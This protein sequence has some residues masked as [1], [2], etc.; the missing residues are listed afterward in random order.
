MMNIQRHE[1]QQRELQVKEMEIVLPFAAISRASLAVAGGKAANLGELTQAGFPVPSGFC[2]TTEAYALVAE[3]AD[4]EPILAELAA[5]RSDDTMQLA[6]VA[7]AVRARLL[8]APMPERVGEAIRKAYGELEH[9]E[10]VPVAVRSSATAE[11]LPFASFAGQQET[12][13]NIIGIEA[14][15]DAVR[16][17]WASLWTDR[18]V[19]Y[20]VSLGIDQRAVRLAVAVQRMVEADVAGVLFTADPLTGRRRQAV[21]DANPGLGEAVVSGAVNPDHFVV[22]TTTGEIVERRLGDKRLVIRATAGGGTQ[23]VELTG[24]NTE[25][26]L[27]DEQIRTLA[28]LGA[29]VEAHYGAPQDTEWA[30]DPS[31][32]LWLLQSRPITTLYPLPDNAPK[33]DDIL[34]AYFSL[35]VFQG[36]YRPLTPMG[37][38]VFRLFGSAIAGVFRLPPRDPLRG[39]SI[40]VEAGG[41][42]FID[43]TAALR[44]AI[45]RKF[46]LAAAQVG[47]APSGA[48]FQQLMTDPRLSLLPTPRWHLI[49]A[50]GSLLEKTRTPLYVLQ[51]LLWPSTVQRRMTQVRV[52][53]QSLN[54]EAAAASVQQGADLTD[55]LTALEQ[56]LPGRV[57]SV[58]RTIPVMMISG[59]G[60]YALSGRLLKGIATADEMRIVL[61][62]LPHNPTTEMDLELWALAERVQADAVAA[63]AVR[64]TLPE[65]LTQQ[66]REGT[67]PTTLQHGLGEFL[68]A[69]GHR[70]VAEIDLGLPRWSE[71]PTHILGVLANYLQ[72]NEPELAPDVQFHRGAQEAE[73]MVATLTRRAWRKGR[74]RGVLV[75]FFLKR[76]RALA[77]FREMPKFCLVL[78]L[79]SIRRSLL[80]IGKA[81]EQVGCLEHAG[82]IFF[83]TLAEARAALA[84]KDLH[85]IVRERRASYDREVQRR[86][87]PRVLLSDGTEPTVALQAGELAEGT[88][89][90]SPASPGRVMAQARVILDPT[91]ARLEPGEVLVAPS[92]DPGW[93]PLFLTA[94][95]LV[96]EMGGSMSHGAV[97]AREYGIPAVVGV[98]GATERITTG[99]QI[100]VDG[101]AGTVYL[102]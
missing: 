54:D 77:G 55:R 50:I 12:Y 65:R 8:A 19:S 98:P 85:Q 36:V 100:T 91:G 64:E 28:A 4:F 63:Q 34:R 89:K 15:L 92:T 97:V 57:T 53:L 94:G 17:C 40:L 7:A 43:V 27:S 13:L 51:A 48:L 76:T 95:G 14:L 82:D 26:C 5:V 83:L 24:G 90:G 78:L 72:L 2:V 73:A 81:M 56:R 31:G 88:L 25:A 41:R 59:L 47:E 10:P 87:I 99:Q 37:I 46:L 42:L 74:L 35:N 39:P 101:S 30:I 96:M 80:S 3:E 68:H 6:K 23:R 67:L 45:G 52:W 102:E 61:R 69:Y 79:A 18:A 20:R 16:L 62:G 38:A 1:Q 32:K 58:F 86:S 49:R 75:R 21:I 9:D 29:R 22:N 33:T 70:G 93:T 60:S 71:D 66:Y 11:D 44:T 84:G